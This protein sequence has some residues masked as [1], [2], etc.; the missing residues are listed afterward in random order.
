MI[1]T[2]IKITTSLLT[3]L[4]LCYPLPVIAQSGQSN[5]TQA[6]TQWFADIQMENGLV[7]SFEPDKPGRARISLYDQALAVI[8][9]SLLENYSAA[10]KILDFFQN[11]IMD[12][13]ESGPGGFFQ[14]RN[15]NGRPLRS[16]A[17]WLGDNAWLLIA[18]QNYRLIS[19]NQNAYQELVGSLENWIKSLQQENGGLIS[20]TR[21]DGSANTNM[22]I[23]G[24]IDA[25]GA[26]PGYTD[27]HEGIL[28]Y[29][30]KE[31]WDHQRQ[32]FIAWPAP[33]DP[34]YKYA[35]DNL[36]W[37]YLAI[38]GF[39]AASLGQAEELFGA[40]RPA[41]GNQPS[42]SGFCYDSSLN[43]I[44]P[45]ATGS[46]IIAYALAGD[47]QKYIHYLRENSRLLMPGKET[48]A[49]AGLP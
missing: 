23:E 32:I 6:I 9:F 24:N 27:F 21:P 15:K 37:G 43:T 4:L 16:S 34:A 14:F 26:I 42:I 49:A 11:Q 29:F 25:F 36:A 45:E 22:V 28:D 12:E 33:P 19:G 30:K 10:E 40:S 7:F 38:K 44:H 5:E 17:R 13:L 48:T 1:L 47:K 20:G 41:A 3:A 8:V 46:M 39:P 31:R 2:R 35:S 18:A